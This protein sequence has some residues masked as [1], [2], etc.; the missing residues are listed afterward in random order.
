MC[1]VL[2]N[3]AMDEEVNNIL[4]NM[5]AEKPIY[6]L[7]NKLNNSQLKWSVIEKECFA[8]HYALQI[9][10]FL[11]PLLSFELTIGL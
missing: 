9:F 2:F 3:T 6:F 7:S 11:G 1:T 5:K 10:T 8:I 4:P